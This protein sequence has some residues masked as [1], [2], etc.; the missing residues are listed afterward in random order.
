M[1]SKPLFLLRRRDRAVDFPA[2]KIR[3]EREVEGDDKDLNRN[4][5]DLYF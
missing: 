3:P 1:G 5:M 2:D 4:K